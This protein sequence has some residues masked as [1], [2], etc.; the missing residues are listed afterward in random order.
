MSPAH[1]GPRSRPFTVEKI[2]NGDDVCCGCGCL[3]KVTLIAPRMSE[4]KEV[5]IPCSPWYVCH[6]CLQWLKSKLIGF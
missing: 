6:G 2:E 3:A 4:N 1:N 5:N